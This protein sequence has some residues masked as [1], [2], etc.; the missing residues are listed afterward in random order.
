MTDYTRHFATL[1]LDFANEGCLHYRRSALPSIVV[2]HFQLHIQRIQSSCKEYNPSGL[3]LV[4]IRKNFSCSDIYDITQT[5]ITFG[6]APPIAPA[7]VFALGL[8]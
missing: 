4:H 8:V 2:D 6:D 1:I 5:G 3:L 7:A